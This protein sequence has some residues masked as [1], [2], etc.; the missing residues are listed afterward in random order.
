MVRLYKTMAIMVLLSIGSIA[1]AA[2]LE[3][4]QLTQTGSSAKIL[5]HYSGGTHP[6]VLTLEHPARLVF[7]FPKTGLRATT[8]LPKAGN[9]L[10]HGFRSGRHGD[11]IRIV[12]DLNTPV[13]VEADT[14]LAQNKTSFVAVMV[15]L[16]QPSQS[17]HKTART[18]MLKTRRHHQT[19]PNPFTVVIDP[20]HGGHDAGALGMRGEQEK[21]IALAIS[22][23]IKARLMRRPGYKVVL[24][25]TSDHYISLRQRLDIARKA[26][27]DLFIAIHADAFYKRS[28]RGASVYVL[29]QRGATSEAAR[30]LAHAEN[31]SEMMG[32]EDLDDDTPLLRSILMDLQQVATIHGS[33]DIG[34]TILN[35]IGHFAD[36][37][38]DTVEQAAFVV[39]KSPDIPSILVETGFISNPAEACNLMT[40]SYQ[41]RIARAVV[42]GILE[43]RASRGH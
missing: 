7:D 12:A 17:Q 31:R 30:W 23:Q 1:H 35:N 9:R 8:I 37:H 24:T 36:L 32:G 28:A 26:H 14:K 21:R 2:Q 13:W 34:Q 4:I 6:T 19:P 3:N 25:R 33:A 20:G 43:Y 5:F 11:G 39:L 42:M 16:S 18:K 15:P 27:A 41:I 10:I 22:R 40:L 29:S 38:H